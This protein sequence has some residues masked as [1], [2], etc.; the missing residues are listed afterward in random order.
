MLQDLTLILR[1]SAAGR[2]LL[3]ANVDEELSPSQRKKL[4]NLI[5]DFY[6]DQEII[7]E[8]EEFGGIAQQIHQRF[9]QEKEVSYSNNILKH[10][11]MLNFFFF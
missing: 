11:I 1:N 7:L 5:L 8:N 9:S 2:A 3:K 4:V 6:V 10:H